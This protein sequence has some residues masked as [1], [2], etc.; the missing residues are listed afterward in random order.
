MAG[1]G[2]R[3]QSRRPEREAE[4]VFGEEK[5][6]LEIYEKRIRGGEQPLSG[7]GVRTCTVWSYGR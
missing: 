6:T 4:I 3:N 2:R 5:D 7:G 1:G